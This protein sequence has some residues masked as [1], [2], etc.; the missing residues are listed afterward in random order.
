M[1]PFIVA[2]SPVHK[3]LTAGPIY[4]KYFS[5]L[6]YWFKIFLLMTVLLKET[7]VFLINVSINSNFQSSE[8]T[9]SLVFYI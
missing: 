1:N 2:Q 4:K 5:I 9:G 7:I 3:Q 6:L 8:T